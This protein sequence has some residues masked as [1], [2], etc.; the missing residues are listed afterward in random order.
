MY[1]NYK[2]PKSYFYLISVNICSFYE[3]KKKQNHQKSILEWKM[4]RH[5]VEKKHK[6]S[7]EVQRLTLGDVWSV[8]W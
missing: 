8:N 5:A 1:F 4:Q 7:E 6:I 3:N 2:L